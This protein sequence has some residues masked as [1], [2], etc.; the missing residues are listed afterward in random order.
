MIF[1]IAMW[2]LCIV[3]AIVSTVTW[4]ITREPKVRIHEPL[5]NEPGSHSRPL[6]LYEPGQFTGGIAII[7][8]SSNDE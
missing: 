4:L 5:T 7:D 1:L 8:P 3:G 2:L 6:A